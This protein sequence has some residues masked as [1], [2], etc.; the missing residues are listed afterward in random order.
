M[1]LINRDVRRGGCKKTKEQLDRSNW[2]RQW[3]GVLHMI[4]IE[5]ITVLIFFY[6]GEAGKINVLQTVKY[7][8]E[9]Q[10]YYNNT[11]IITKKIHD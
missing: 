6:K 1:I 2:R 4:M 9:T 3:S 10:V 7:D 8:I 11:E 5:R